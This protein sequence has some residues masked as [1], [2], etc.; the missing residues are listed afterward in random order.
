MEKMVVITL[1]LVDIV[2]VTPRLH[3]DG[4]VFRKFYPSRSHITFSCS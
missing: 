4:S 3:A 2:L 1:N